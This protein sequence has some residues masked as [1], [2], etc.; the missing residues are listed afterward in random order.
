M[1]INDFENVEE[2][3]YEFESATFTSGGPALSKMGQLVH[4]SLET[5][6]TLEKALSDALDKAF[7]LG[8][9]VG[10]GEAREEIAREIDEEDSA[11]AG[12]AADAIR[13]GGASIDD[14]K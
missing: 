4:D 8:Y 14:K 7:E 6:E 12:W 2:P 5:K 3:L 10:L 11:C 9:E 1:S 13:R